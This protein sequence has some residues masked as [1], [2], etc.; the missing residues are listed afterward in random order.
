[1]QAQREEGPWLTL[2]VGV[3]GCRSG[4]GSRQRRTPARQGQRGVVGAARVLMSRGVGCADRRSATLRPAQKSACNT[5]PLQL[6]PVK[7]TVL[8]HSGTH[9]STPSPCPAA[10]LVHPRAPARQT[11]AGQHV[12][13]P[14]CCLLC[15]AG[16][17]QLV[18]CYVFVMLLLA[19][20][21]PQ[22]DAGTA[23]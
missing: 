20:H 15:L 3:V 18:G 13:E 5:C 10:V 22:H 21:T 8:T 23:C 19:I 1:M 17:G 6:Q 2:R 7:E 9:A 12:A 4:Q 14:R 11:A 16:C